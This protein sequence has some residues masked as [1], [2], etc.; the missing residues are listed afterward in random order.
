MN[1]CIEIGRLANGQVAF[2]DTKD[3]SQPALIF[4]N[5]EWLAF[6][7]GIRAGEFDDL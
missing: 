4:A 2:R 5:E 3:R 1:G 6:V 7:A